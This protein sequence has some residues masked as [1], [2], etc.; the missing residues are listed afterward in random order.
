[1]YIE[2]RFAQGDQPVFIRAKDIHI[3]IDALEDTLRRR[4]SIGGSGFD[5]GQ[6]DR[7]QTHD[8]LIRSVGSLQHSED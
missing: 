7:G 5:D 4:D 2:Q 1:M 3:R 8:D 6:F